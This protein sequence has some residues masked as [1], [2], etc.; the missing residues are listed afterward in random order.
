MFRDRRSLVFR[1]TSG[2]ALRAFGAVAV[3][4]LLAPQAL[5]AQKRVEKRVDAR[6]DGRVTISNVAGSVEVVGW[7]E[8]AVEVVADLSSGVEELQVRSQGRETEIEV[9]LVRGNRHRGGNAVLEVRVPRGSD[10]EIEVVSASVDVEDVEGEINIESVSGSIDVSGRSEGLEM[11][12]VSGSIDVDGAT[13]RLDAE[14]VS[15]RIRL[16]GAAREIDAST[17]S[18]QLELEGE[19]IDRADLSTVSG[20]IELSG[21]LSADAEIEIESHSGGVEL[22]LPASAS[23]RFSVVTYSG[24][25]DNELGPPA[26]RTGRYTPGKELDFT[27]GGGDARVTIESFSGSVSLRRR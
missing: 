18:G 25:I 7:S 17:V 6:P 16:R 8:A 5:E 22:R 4:A 19:E 1:K 14:S 11:E 10:L 27:M 24:R 26:R 12:S 13:G 3:V 15:G 9:E 23:A 21:S 2:S 20:G